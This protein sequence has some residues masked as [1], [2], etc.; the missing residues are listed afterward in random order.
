MPEICSW[1]I[2]A[3]AAASATWLTLSKSLATAQDEDD[4]EMHQHHMD[5]L[6]HQQQHT[7]FIIGESEERDHIAH[8]LVQWTLRPL[9]EK[10]RKDTSRIVTLYLVFLLLST[11]S[12]WRGCQVT[13]NF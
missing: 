9:S 13:T 12:T 2:V 8:H 6:H 7:D 11:R 10:Q 4:S 3:A 5:L 1:L